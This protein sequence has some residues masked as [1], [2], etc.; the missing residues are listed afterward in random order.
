LTLLE[1][2]VSM[3]IFLLSISAIFHLLS[4]GTDAAIEV[5]LQTRTSM[6]CQGKMAEVMCGAQALSSTGSYSNFDDS[7]PDKDLQ[8]RLEA[9][10][11]DDVQMLW[12]VKVWVKADLPSGQTIESQLCQMVLNPSS[13]GT[14]FDQTQMPN[15][16]QASSS[17]STGN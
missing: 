6:R 5:R 8:W 11:M 15:S 2:I 3:A 14:T 16:G 10:P 12:M 7:D 1:V 9:T 17:S 13:R 4:V